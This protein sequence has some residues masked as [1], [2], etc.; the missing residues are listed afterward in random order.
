MQQSN[1]RKEEFILTCSSEN[2]ILLC[3]ESIV[4]ETDWFV[5]TGHAMSDFLMAPRSSG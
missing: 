3:E 5:V 2:T 1:L 4:A